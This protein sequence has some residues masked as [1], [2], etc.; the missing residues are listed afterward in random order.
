MPHSVTVGG[1]THVAPLQHPVGQ[2]AGEQPLHTPAVHVPPGQIWQ[3]FPPVPHAPGSSVV[4]QAP[5]EQHP[6]GH[7]VLSQVQ[8]PFT[9]SCPETQALPP[10][11][12]HV[13]A[14]LHPSP[15]LPQPAHDTPGPA[16]A[17]AV[18]ASHRLPLQHPVAQDVA[19]HTHAPP[20][21]ACPTPHSPLV[22]HEQEPPRQPSARPLAQGAQVAPFVP[23]ISSVKVVTHVA[24]EQHP[25]A[26]D[27]ALQTHPPP[28]HS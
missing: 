9:H 13:P 20:E 19:L 27:V 23:Q 16:Q 1:V 11:H 10:P 26:H 24:P 8:T 7:E 17:V 4:T 3:A 18:S 22:P 14:M 5:A 15:V 25:V 12:V 6:F 2:V 21:Q 28:T